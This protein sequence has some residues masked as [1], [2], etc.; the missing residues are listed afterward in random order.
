[1]ALTNCRPGSLPRARNN[2]SSKG[3]SVKEFMVYLL[4]GIRKDLHY[5]GIMQ[6]L[7][8]QADLQSR[9]TEAGV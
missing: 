1:M 4:Y 3:K 9:L 6:K 8:R 7:R 5:G 2:L